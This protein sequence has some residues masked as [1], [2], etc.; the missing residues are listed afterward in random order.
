VLE[1]ADL[2]TTQKTSRM[3]L[4]RLGPRRLSEE[5]TWITTCH[6]LLEAR[7]DSLAEFLD[8]T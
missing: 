7:L 2:V 8:R 4:Y 1:A 5:S 6:Q 3:R